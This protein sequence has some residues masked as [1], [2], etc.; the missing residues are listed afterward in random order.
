MRNKICQNMSN[1]SSTLSIG[2][3]GEGLFGGLPTL[4]LWLSCPLTRID[5][6]FFAANFLLCFFNQ[7]YIQW[8]WHECAPG[9]LYSGCINTPNRALLPRPF[10]PFYSLPIGSSCRWPSLDQ[11]HC[12]VT[13]LPEPMRLGQIFGTNLS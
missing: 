7:I 4:L 5:L 11:S 3:G 1:V 6:R 8:C 10:C 13:K 2:G 12:C 9:T